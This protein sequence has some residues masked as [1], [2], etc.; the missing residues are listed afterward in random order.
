MLKT[1][2]F[3]VRFV[4]PCLLLLLLVLFSLNLSRAQ[5]KNKSVS[6][7]SENLPDSVKV[8][9]LVD[10][11]S[12]SVFGSL[13]T[14]LAII[15]QLEQI[16]GNYA[17]GN[18]LNSYALYYKMKNDYFAALRYYQL[19]YEFYKEQKD[20]EGIAA[21][22]TGIAFVKGKKMQRYNE[23]LENLNEALR[24]F[25]NLNQNQSISSTY[26]NIASIYQEIG[27]Y[28][29]ALVNHRNALDYLLPRGNPLLI[30]T[31]HNNIA[32][33]YFKLKNYELSKANYLRAFKLAEAQNNNLIMASA[34]NGLA[35][36][37]IQLNELKEAEKYLSLSAQI[38]ENQK[39]TENKIKLY[40]NFYLLYQA[41]NNPQKALEYFL[42]HTKLRDSLE[43]QNFVA[44]IFA[45][46]NQFET[47]EKDKEIELLQKEKDLQ[48][49]RL[50]RQNLILVSA[51]LSGLLLV[52]IIL[53]LINNIK[54]SRETNKLLVEKN[55]LTEENQKQLSLVNHKLENENIVAQYETLKNQVNPHF[56]FNSLH[57]LSQ[58]I[59]DSTEKA[60]QFVNSFAKFY[61]SIL[62]SDGEK[63]NPLSQEISILEDYLYL[64][65]IR[66]E[67]KITTQIDD[68]L[69]Q[70]NSLLP[71]LSLQMLVENAVKHNKLSSKSPLNII[72]AKENDYLVIKNNLQRRET[73]P[74]STGIGIKN[75]KNRYK[76]FTDKTCQFQEEEGYFIAKIP[77]L[78]TN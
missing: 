58:L 5:S 70:E 49:S 11:Y 51:S 22:L 60:T 55:R 42:A 47:L 66:F 35:R 29:L 64:L 6:I 30:A 77:L 48:E 18:T 53:L 34:S 67:D 59:E 61:K 68:K 39:L 2:R 1:I 65:K 3:L 71:A 26:S 7:L 15:K 28:T 13:D 76:F 9:L 20:N 36:V 32:T 10:L 27:D 63:L 52:I 33:A 69:A 4:K 24:I 73:T 38:S 16:E 74:E 56:L 21:A 14:A 44:E 54:K 50:K 25:I 62:Q 78:K 12:A 43:N 72:I 23:A 40:H 37:L 17:K 46:Q 8:D 45:L 19:S 41:Q 75:L 31:A 57:V